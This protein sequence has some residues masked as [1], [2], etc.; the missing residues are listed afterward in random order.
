MVA[1]LLI[2]RNRRFLTG[3]ES[4]ARIRQAV[5]DRLKEMPEIARVSYLRLEFVG[6]RQLLL[7]ASIDLQGEQ[8]ES[9]VAYTLREL[10]NRIEEDPV[11]VDAVLTLA[12]PDEQSI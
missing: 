11:L 8:R 9:A 3:Q 7:V 5:L 1:V 6:P 2:N 12:T 4:D 10:E